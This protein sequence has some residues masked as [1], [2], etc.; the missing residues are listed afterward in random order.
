M[1][2]SR[3]QLRKD[4]VRMLALFHLFISHFAKPI[5]IFRLQND[6]KETTEP[7]L[8]GIWTYIHLS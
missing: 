5:L 6:L 7:L 3:K 2:N 8:F 1:K 4:M